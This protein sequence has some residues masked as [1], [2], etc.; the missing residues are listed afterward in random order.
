[1]H[2]R[3]PQDEFVILGCD[4]VWDVFSSEEGVSNMREIFLAGET[5]MLKCA[6]ELI[7]M[8]LSKGK[9]QFSLMLCVYRESDECPFAFSLWG[10]GSRDNISV[11][12]VKLPG[13]NIGPKENGGVDKL[14]LE[15]AQA[16][17]E[18]EKHD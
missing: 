12:V 3:T 4:G 13:A 16:A 11:A 8:A 15:R 10:A 9:S 1:M 17:A 18:G 5:S 2:N 14:R 7:D 6:E